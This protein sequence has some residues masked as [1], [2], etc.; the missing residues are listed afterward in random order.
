MKINIL[1]LLFAFLISNSI[2]A[3]FEQ[4]VRMSIPPIDKPTSIDAGDLDGDG[5]LDLLFSSKFDNRITWCEHVENGNFKDKKDISSDIFYASW[6]SAVDIDIDGD[7]DVLVASFQDNKISMFENNGLGEFGN[8]QMISNLMTRPSYVTAKDVDGDALPD[9]IYGTNNTLTPSEIGFIRNLG[10]ANFSPITVISNQLSNVKKC[11]VL[12]IDND[13]DVDI[14][15]QD[16]TR[17]NLH[18][19]NG[20][21]NFSTIYN[22]TQTPNYEMYN[23]SVGDLNND[24]LKDIIFSL[25]D[26]NNI[27]G[28]LNNGNGAFGLPQIL[29]N[30]PTQALSLTARDFDGDNDLDIAFTKVQS[31]EIIWVENTNGGTFNVEHILG[32]L[33][34]Y[35]SGF[36]LKFLTSFDID[37][38]G[39]FEIISA[40]IEDDITECFLNVGTGAFNNSTIVSGQTKITVNL[41][42]SDIDNDG[43]QDIVSSTLGSNNPG[44]ISWFKNLGN[45]S[46][47]YPRLISTELNGSYRLH[48]DDLDNDGL[49]EILICPGSSNC[50]SLKNDGTGVFT[51]VQSFSFVSSTTKI[52]SFDYDVDGD[53]DLFFSDPNGIK[54]FNN[55]GGGIFGSGQLIASVQ[56]SDMNQKDWNNDGLVDIVFSKTNAIC[57]MQNL[58]NGSFSIPFTVANTSFGAGYF[59]LADVDN[60]NDFDIV[61]TASNVTPN[62]VGMYRNLG[63]NSF[64]AMELISNQLTTPSNPTVSDID[65]DNHSD[66]VIGSYTDTL[67]VCFLND[68]SGFFN[69]Y[70]EISSKIEP[71]KLL[72]FDF[73]LDGDS[74]VFSSG[75]KNV[76]MFKNGIFSDNQARGL[77]YYDQNQNGIFDST[78]QGL[79]LG[80]I[81][82]LPENSYAF[83]N[84]SG[85]YYVNLDSSLPG[86]YEIVP[87]NFSNWSVTSDS[88]SYH[89]LVDNSFNYVD[90]LNFGFYPSTFFDSISPTLTGG[91]PRCNSTVNYWASIKNTG[92]KL[93][94]GILDIALDPQ[95]TFITSEIPPDSV[96]GGHIYWH[97]DS[98]FFLESS[99]FRFTV[100]MPDFNSIGDTLT[101]SLLVKTID[102][103]DLV[104]SQNTDTLNQILVCAYDP[105]RKTV[106]PEGEGPLG[107]I[108]SNTQALEYQIDFQNTGND[109]AINVILKD[110]LNS[111]LIWSSI[112]PLAS[113]HPFELKVL[114]GG[115]I[116]FEFDQIMLPD[117]STNEIESHGFVKY[118]INLKPNLIPE[119]AITNYALIYFDLNPAII[120]DTTLNT[121]KPEQSANQFELESIA[122]KDVFVYPNPYTDQLNIVFSNIEP[123]IISLYSL[124]GKRILE[125]TDFDKDKISLTLSDLKAGLYFLNVKCTNPIQEYNLKIVKSK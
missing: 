109:T 3:Q 10:N 39:D 34:S 53:I 7:L 92:T 111:N 86:P 87:I 74:D 66:V 91:Y 56:V 36:N 106:F 67:I 51:N 64:G 89:I 75:S 73:D 59:V 60:Q 65:G 80:E 15:S 9:I 93:S 52:I 50:I 24:N 81:I 27:K 4:E 32:S 107:Y 124:S 122:E 19:N 49:P 20:A 40:S 113:S 82:T 83:T 121:I 38:D 2:I 14:L 97:F 6:A 99:N 45:G 47:D 41:I 16:F 84:S 103:Q 77:L 28:C 46:F 26:A 96:V 54:L 95:I 23:F 118:R 119:T 72:N 11:E 57:W 44:V 17:I 102:E 55:L 69:N 76:S 18:K 42:N 37:I 31:A 29:V 78:D 117:S 110:Y 62:I 98:L 105:N 104:T 100:Q 58:G 94:S 25:T 71:W 115:E 21:G 8:E 63:G 108:S 90:S 33:L 120:T 1:N 35:T 22:I 114:P 48:A 123:S 101:S 70:D 12:D 13:G 79:D 125:L 61:F 30:L 43:L 5:D 112:T 116:R 85:N 88:A 68:G